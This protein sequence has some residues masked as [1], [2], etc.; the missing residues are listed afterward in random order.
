MGGRVT[1]CGSANS[2]IVS[3]SETIR[4]S[5][6]I[7]SLQKITDSLKAIG[8]FCETTTKSMHR[9]CFFKIGAGFI[10]SRYS[11]PL[12]M[13]SAESCPRTVGLSRH[14]CKRVL[15]RRIVYRIDIY[16]LSVLCYNNFTDIYEFTKNQTVNSQQNRLQ[17]R[18]II[19]RRCVFSQ[20]SHKDYIF[21]TRE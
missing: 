2:I 15:C 3:Q 18:C 10:S 7:Q 20:K 11:Y 12:A 1:C 13:M 21:L 8:Y 5:S 19:G 16:S 14:A 9:Q 17:T 4:G 6:S